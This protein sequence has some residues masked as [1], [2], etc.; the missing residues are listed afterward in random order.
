[1]S[2]TMEQIYRVQEREA[3][4][5]DLQDVATYV[6]VMATWQCGDV[7]AVGTTNIPCK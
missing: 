2:L 3:G 4:N 7:I 1:M 5:W 6:V